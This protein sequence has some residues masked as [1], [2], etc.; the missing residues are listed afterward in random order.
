[1]TGQEIVNHF[2]WMGAELVY[3]NRGRYSHYFYIYFPPLFTIQ[4]RPRMII[5][6]EI[7]LVTSL[8]CFILGDIPYNHNVRKNNVCASNIVL[9]EDI[10]TLFHATSNGYAQHTYEKSLEIFPYIVPGVH[11]FNRTYHTNEDYDF[12]SLLSVSYK[13]EISV[14]NENNIIL[15]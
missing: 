1:M 5:R 8:N 14:F 4:Y 15:L 6:V 10:S 2:E 3:E 11:N 7:G 12:T 13:D 9:I